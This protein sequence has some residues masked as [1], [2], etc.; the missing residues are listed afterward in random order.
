MENSKKP[1]LPSSIHGPEWRAKLSSDCHPVVPQAASHYSNQI[2]G[3]PALPLIPQKKIP[4][5]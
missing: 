3:Y 1:H 2:T 4:R 5:G